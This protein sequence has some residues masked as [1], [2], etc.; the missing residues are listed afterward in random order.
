VSAWG[1]AKLRD[2]LTVER[3]TRDGYQDRGDWLASCVWCGLD[4]WARKGEA[5]WGCCSAEC[6]GR[7][8]YWSVLARYGR[9]FLNRRWAEGQR[10]RRAARKAA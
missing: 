1:T 10:R 2:D 3:L 8:A 4:Y 7:R 5:Q 6:R 9:A